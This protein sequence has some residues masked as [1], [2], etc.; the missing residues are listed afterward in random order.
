MA[1]FSKSMKSA[2]RCS[3]WLDAK[4]LPPAG[5]SG[6]TPPTRTRRVPG[7][8]ARESPGPRG[9]FTLPQAAAAR[10]RPT[11]RTSTS[12][13][14]REPAAQDLGHAPGLGHAAARGVGRLGVEDFADGADAGLAQVGPEAL[15]EGPRAGALTRME[16][17]PGV[18]VG[19]D[20]PGPDRAL[21]IGGVPR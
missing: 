19:S 17:E 12:R 8:G 6:R 13:L 7:R 4:S 21:V 9:N 1:M 18:D 15:Q 16:L 14:R 10:K 2:S 3:S 20:E 5:V 11:R